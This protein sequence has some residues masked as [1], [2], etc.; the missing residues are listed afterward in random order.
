LGWLHDKDH[1]MK[2]MKGNALQTILAILLTTPAVAAPTVYTDEASFLAAVQQLTHDALVHEGFESDLAWGGVRSTDAGGPVTAATVASQG[3]IW[4]S[5]NSTSQVTTGSGG[6]LTG[7][8][9]FYALPHGS[10][11]SPEPGSDC[12]IPGDCGDGLTIS[13]GAGTI[14]AAGGWFRTN[15]PFAKVG[16]FVGGYTWFGDQCN[17]EGVDCDAVTIGV[18]PQF[19]GLVDAGGF[20][21]IEFRELEGKTEGAF[22]GDLK[23]IFSDDFSVAM[24]VAPQRVP[25]LSASLVLTLGSA[26]ALVG[27]SRLRS[28]A[29]DRRGS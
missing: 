2:R 7:A 21:D 11:A 18:S 19:I 5:N 22:E 15:T 17:L 24:D 16:A 13:S 3:L 9:G 10:Y 25:S 6:A 8:W 26:I 20:T 23:L 28:A 29:S 27:A 14:Y 1:A 4:R 12:D